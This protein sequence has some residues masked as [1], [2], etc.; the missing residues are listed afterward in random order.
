MADSMN[1]PDADG[2]PTVKNFADLGYPKYFINPM[3][4]DMYH[5]PNMFESPENYEP[6][7]FCP[8]DLSLEDSPSFINERFEVVYKLGW[9]GFGTVW[10]CYEEAVKKWRAVKVGA[11]SE[12]EQRSGDILVQSAMK[13]HN[14][15]VA[16]AWE[17]NIALPLETFWIDS[18]NGRHLCTVLPLLGPRLSDWVRFIEEEEPGQAQRIVSQMVQGMGFLHRHGICHGDFRPQNILM[19]L[20][21][22]S[23]SLEDMGFDEMFDEVLGAPQMV[24]I[25]LCNFSPSPHAP[26]TSYSC[27]TWDRKTVSRFITDQIA[28]VDFGEAYLSTDPNPRTP[29]IPGSYAAPEVML[30]LHKGIG[31][32]IWAL[33]RSILEFRSRSFYSEAHDTYSRV[34]EMEEFV[35]PCPATFRRRFQKELDIPFDDDE[36]RMNPEKYYLFDGSAF[37]FQK[38]EKEYDHHIELFLHLMGWRSWELS[39]EEILS[40]G[41]LLRNMFRWK[42]EERWPTEKILAHRWFAEHHQPAMSYNRDGT[43]KSKNK[44]PDNENEHE[45]L[46]SV[47]PEIDAV[48]SPTEPIEPVEPTKATEEAVQ[49]SN[50]A[51]TETETQKKPDKSWRKAAWLCLGVFTMAFYLSGVI[52]MISFFLAHMLANQPGFYANRPGLVRGINGAASQMSPVIQHVVITFTLQA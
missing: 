16:E 23:G 48:D 45:I 44:S 31:A 51:L 39:R 49:E 18:I 10:L 2:V 33:A 34:W 37:G 14:V 5:D 50:T 41:D 9:G 26:K 47:C 32:D 17:N 19:Q 35:G 27:F 24:Y 36:D 28:I 30:D 13:Q 1:T 3:Y 6:G 22:G 11:A 8:I 40:L 52:A 46:P 42:P 15:G 21:T 38:L 43:L 12:T 7:G 4:Q 25:L 20:K 29:G